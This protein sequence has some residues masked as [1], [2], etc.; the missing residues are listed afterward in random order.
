MDL[1]IYKVIIAPVISEKAYKIGVDGTKV[2]FRV[3]PSANKTVIKQAVEKLFNV[4]VDKVATA[5][6]KGKMR[7]VRRVVS[8]GILTKRAFITLAA[9][10]KIE[11]FNQ[12]TPHQMPEGEKE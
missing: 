11:L 9:G 12:A 2:V 10:Y 8:H 7:R 1:S 3:H 5:I 4:K 6:R